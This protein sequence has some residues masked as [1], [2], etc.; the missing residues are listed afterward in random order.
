MANPDLP[1]DHPVERPAVQHLRSP[2]RG[3]AGDMDI[4]LLQSLATVFLTAQ[5]PV[6]LE[7]AHR[8]DP[9]AELDQMHRHQ[10]VPA[11]R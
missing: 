4:N 7:L 6:F 5:N 10:S 9:N 11:G 1:A 8:V 3:I 2:A